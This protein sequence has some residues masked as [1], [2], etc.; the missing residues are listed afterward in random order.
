MKTKTKKPDSIADRQML[1]KINN[2]KIA[3]RFTD[4][5][6]VV[7]RARPGDRKYP[8][9]PRFWLERGHDDQDR[10]GWKLLIHPDDDEPSHCIF[11]ADE[12]RKTIVYDDSDPTLTGP[13][14]TDTY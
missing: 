12:D 8:T 7:D 6:L 2:V 5:V 13:E 4:S 1:G 14:A 3:V 11:I 9:G 10:S